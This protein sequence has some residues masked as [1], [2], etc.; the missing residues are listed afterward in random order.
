MG[1]DYGQNIHPKCLEVSICQSGTHISV[2]WYVQK[3]QGVF[4]NEAEQ[5]HVN[6]C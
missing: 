2:A 1:F 3:R 4:G 6:I 5:E